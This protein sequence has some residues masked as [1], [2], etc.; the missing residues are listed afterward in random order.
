MLL[1]HWFEN[2]FS[3]APGFDFHVPKPK[4]GILWPD[5]NNLVGT[6]LLAMMVINL[7]LLLLLFDDCMQNISIVVNII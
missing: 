4:V 2:V 1:L 6:T 3:T 7:L 5:V